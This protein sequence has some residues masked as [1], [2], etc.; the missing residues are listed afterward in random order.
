MTYKNL[1]SIESNMSSKPLSIALVMVCIYMF[2]VIERPWES[3]RY[4]EGIPM[5]R[6]FAV[7]MIFVA[8]MTGRFRIISSPM[9]KWVYG[10]LA[11]HF[12]LAPFAYNSN[13]A[14]DQGIEYAKMVV[15]YLLILSV[16][17][18]EHS[19][20]I[21][22]KA[23]VFSMMFYML[24]SL[25]EYHNGRHVWTMG[26]SRMVGVDKT[27]NDPNAFGASLVLSVPLAFS[28]FRSETG[29]KLRIF[30][31]A[32]FSN[33]VLC[34]VL[35]GS[36]SASLA[37]VFLVLLWA[38]MQ[39]GKRK[40]I[41][42]SL[43]LMSLSALWVSMPSNK[44]ERIRSIWDTEAGPANAHKST[45]GRRLGY[46]AGLQMFKQAPFTG[47]GAGGK[48]FV[49]YRMNELDGISEQ[50]HNLYVEVLG[51]FGV[52]GAFFFIG[53][54]S[55]ILLSCLKVRQHCLRF[56]VINSLTYDI[57]GAIIICLILLLLLGFAGH[58]FY[59][60]L[61]LWLAAWSGGMLHFMKQTKDYIE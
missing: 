8:I 43:T 10:L 26:I 19:F 33:V 7:V 18:D 46:L 6:I 22:I 20:K 15:L 53:L 21:L 11:L 35:T 25:W 42:V 2:L 37:F 48:N 39:R 52:A 41:I 29:R 60:P 5:E 23:Y 28:L 3:I 13:Y 32:Y 30:Y 50:A 4:L 17:D 57:S 1:N 49:G 44:Q 16:V 24:H 38:L 45:E 47:V 55:S 27:F 61:W 56:N 31:F 14:F 12:I 51:E 9:N 58:N 34:I 36:R 59:R 54:V 40:I